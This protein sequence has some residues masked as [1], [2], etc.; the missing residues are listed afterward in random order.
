MDSPSNPGHTFEAAGNDSS[1]IFSDQ[2]IHRHQRGERW[3]IE[4]N[5]WTT[6]RR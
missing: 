6:G 5:I 2:S 1:C 3:D 4:L